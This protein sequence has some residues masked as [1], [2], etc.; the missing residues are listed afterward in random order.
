MAHGVVGHGVGVHQGGSS[1]AQ[2]LAVPILPG[3]IQRLQQSGSTVDI[4]SLG[5]EC[6]RH[7][8]VNGEERW[9]LLCML[10][11]VPAPNQCQINRNEI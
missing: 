5:A 3:V 7:L 4:V 11:P 1:M 10:S 2:E 9:P 6:L 8:R